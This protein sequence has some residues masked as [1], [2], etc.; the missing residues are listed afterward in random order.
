[1]VGSCFTRDELALRTG[2]YSDNTAA[3]IL[4]RYLGGVDALNHYA[5]A[6]GMNNSALWIPNTT[7]PDDLSQ[8]LVSEALGRLGGAAAQGGLYPIV[9]HT[10]AEQGIT[11]GLPGGASVVH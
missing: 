9:T 1:Q 11:A 8:A 2:R 10:A 3:H 5:T 6:I 7:T 4:V